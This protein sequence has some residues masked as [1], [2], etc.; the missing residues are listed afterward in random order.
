MAR[1]KRA[2]KA[3]HLASL[4]KHPVLVEKL[5]D[6]L[7][8]DRYWSRALTPESCFDFTFHLAIFRE[9]YLRFILEGQKTVETR[10]ARRA[11]PPFGKVAKGDVLLLKRAA[12]P[13]VA[14]CLVDQ[15]WFYRLEAGSLDTIRERFGAAICPAA[16]SFWK[17]RENA[18]FATLML[19]SHV[20]PVNDLELKKRDRRGWV[21]FE[22][23]RRDL[24]SHEC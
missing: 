16:D 13:I 9:P 7:S 22:N 15:V 19:I 4:F 24:L 3:Q 2:T 1:S 14:I 21:T 17:E 12:G 5:R 20:T 23:P 10:F 18:A 6:I 8:R 11:C